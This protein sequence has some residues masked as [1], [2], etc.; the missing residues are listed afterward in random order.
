[1][2]TPAQ[3]PLDWPIAIPRTKRP[4]STPFK[5]TLTV[6]SD[7]LLEELDRLLSAE[8]FRT[9]V[10]SSNM[11]YRRD[12]IPYAN[13]REPEDPGVAVYFTHEGRPRV[14][15][16]DRFDKVR[17]NIRAIGLTI[18][19]LRGI[20]RWGSRD[21]LDRAFQGFEAL[22]PPEAVS[23]PVPR[24][25]HWS[26]VLEVDPASDRQTIRRA[27]L[28]KAAKA[29]PDRGGTDAD[30]HEIAS[31]WLEARRQFDQR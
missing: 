11:R 28:L 25:R 17:G 2:H 10:I 3:S 8:N 7:D 13:Q 14:F 9:I 31:A 21:M 23:A 15:A 4:A 18:A 22:P 29:H 26:E 24:S 16:C 5:V 19:A 27:Y 30:F 20:E 12:G 6:A 1:M